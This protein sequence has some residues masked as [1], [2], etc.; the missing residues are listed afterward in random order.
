[1]GI[2]KL[3]KNLYN[4]CRIL[5]EQMC[6]QEQCLKK[7]NFLHK[8][9]QKKKIRLAPLGEGIHIISTLATPL[10]SIILYGL[11]PLDPPLRF[12]PKAYNPLI[13]FDCRLHQKEDVVLKQLFARDQ[14]TQ[15]WTTIGPR[16]AFNNEQSPYR[17]VS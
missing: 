8:I 13:V 6:L 3:N 11:G 14:T 17:I 10:N 5:W 12:R 9:V 4:Q 15:K 16:T 7:Y 1:M 2:L